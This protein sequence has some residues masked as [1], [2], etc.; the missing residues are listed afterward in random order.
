MSPSLTNNKKG[1][2]ELHV[3]DAPCVKYSDIY[4]LGNISWE[5]FAL[6][7]LKIPMHRM[8]DPS[9]QGVSYFY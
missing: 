6:V 2:K 7:T 3:A 1:V 8:I 5:W 9:H 4:I